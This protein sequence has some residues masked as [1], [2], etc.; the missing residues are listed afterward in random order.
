MSSDG[1]LSSENQGLHAIASAASIAGEAAIAIESMRRQL[2]HGW[3]S[4][5][6]KEEDRAIASRGRRE[7][8]A[9]IIEP[10]MGDGMRRNRL[11]ITQP[12]Q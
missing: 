10:D 7:A 9:Y 11:Q 4:L 1:W 6:I 8:P 2:Y 5:P 12:L 3:K